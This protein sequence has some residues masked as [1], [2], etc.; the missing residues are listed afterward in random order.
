MKKIMLF[1]VSMTM[2]LGLGAQ[3]VDIE[4]SDVT[5]TSVT[6]ILTPDQG[7]SS[8]TYMISEPGG[9]ESYIGS[10]FPPGIVIGS[11]EDCISAWGITATAT[12]TH[13]FTGLAPATTQVI[14]VL[15]NGTLVTDT[16]STATLG[17]DGLSVITISVDEIGD[18]YATTHCY[19]NA[20]TAV[21]KNLVI[22]QSYFNEIGEDSALA[23]VKEDPYPFYEDYHWTW[24]SLDP[25]TPYYFLA[26]GQNALGEWGPM[27]S[28]AFTTTG[29]QGIQNAAQSQFIV[30]PNPAKSVIYLQDVPATA[31]VQL[32]DLSG[33]ILSKC[34]GS[35]SISVAEY[36]QGVYYVR[37]ICGEDVS[38]Q[39]V[40]IGE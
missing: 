15:V 27:Q 8:Y 12:E 30:Y 22:T 19:P 28:F 20:E 5:T 9:L 29:Q 24:R 31:Q 16:T 36:P 33:R 26:V 11:I 25:G 10:V 2:F 39:K 7:V 34:S 35:S 32:I 3:T 23:M 4:V 37:I 1:F 14:Y 6:V 17:G 13:T 38:V 18:T 21:Y 40:L